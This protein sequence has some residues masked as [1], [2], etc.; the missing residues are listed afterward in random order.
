MGQAGTNLPKTVTLWSSSFHLQ[1]ICSDSGSKT[2]VS[3]I[4]WAINGGPEQ[5]GGTDN[6]FKKLEA[7][8]LDF[9]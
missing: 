6:M 3:I 8:Q 5:E 9:S 4:V 7:S 1:A 2:T